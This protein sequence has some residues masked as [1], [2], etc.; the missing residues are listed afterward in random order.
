MPTALIPDQTQMCRPRS[1]VKP[2]GMKP[3]LLARSVSFPVVFPALCGVTVA[4]SVLT[5]EGKSSGFDLMPE[6]QSLTLALQLSFSPPGLD[7]S[8]AL[9]LL[10]LPLLHPPCLLPP[11]LRLL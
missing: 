7:V 2:S 3:L 9:H 4:A 1:R 5:L 8:G 11:P 10:S 6:Q